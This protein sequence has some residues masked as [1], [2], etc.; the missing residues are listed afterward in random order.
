MGAVLGKWATIPTTY[1]G[2]AKGEIA[3]AVLACFS[4]AL[5]YIGLEHGSAA[6]RWK[7]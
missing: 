6:F 3:M 2:G 1:A 7:S 5:R 4:L